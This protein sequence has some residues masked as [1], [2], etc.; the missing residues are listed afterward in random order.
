M[1]TCVITVNYKGADVTARCIASL[2]RSS[3]PVSIVVVD[4]TPDD[5]LLVTY[6]KDY[7]D[8]TIISAPKNLGFGEGNNLGLAWAIKNLDFTQ[9]LFLNNDAEIVSNTIAVLEAVLDSKHDVGI[10]T[11]RIVLANSPDT[12]WYGGG[13]VD[14][15]RGSGH[16]PG[17][18]GPSDSTIAMHSRYV[19]FAS[20]CA[21][22]LRRCVFESIGCFDSRYFMYEEDLELCLRV[23][24]DG[25]KVW[26][27]SSAL[28]Y[29]EGQASMKTDNDKEFKSAWN[30][31]NGNLPFYAYHIFKNRLLT[32]Y[33]YAR[34]GNRAIFLLYFPFFIGIKVIRFIR[35][36]R[37]SS[38]TA[39]VKAWRDYRKE[40]KP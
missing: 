30:P 17:F 25:W 29:H 24:Q 28:V 40:V 18:L 12:L 1:G 23:Q 2:M 38:I 14:W 13:E 15:K 39:I 34:G 31:E 35:H 11:G 32:M 21:L 36:G 16:L 10:A 19:S 26:Y 20:G 7:P 33:L 8:V 22:M 5:P 3:V 4:N 27:E 6:L 9:V 37:W